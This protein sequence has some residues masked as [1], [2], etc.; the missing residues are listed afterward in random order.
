MRDAPEKIWATPDIYERVDWRFGEWAEQEP[1]TKTKML[2]R[3]ADLPLTTDQLL[4]DPR[5]KALVEAAE[6]LDKAA[7]EVSRRGAVTGPQWT[8]LTIALLNARAALAQ[9][10]EP[11]E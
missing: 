3:R 6:A 5:V 10:K 1:D 4:A 8:K 11:K 2:Y 9:L 7:S